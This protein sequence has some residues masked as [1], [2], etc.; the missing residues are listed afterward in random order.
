MD[1][2]S[3]HIT[4]NEAIRSDTAKK[5]G[6]KNIPDDS[7][8]HRMRLLAENVFEPLRKYFNVPVYISSFFRSAEINKKIKGAKSSQHILGEAIDLDADI[9]GGVTNREIFNYIKDN[10]E[11]DQL[12][13]EL[14]DDNGTGGWVHVSYKKDGNRKEILKAYKDSKGIMKY[15][16]IN[17]I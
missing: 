8:L 7:Q 11:F 5:F 4:Y 17:N 13:D 1:N 3:E 12:I 10:L 16:K 9:F 2:I 15:K 6:I 14:I